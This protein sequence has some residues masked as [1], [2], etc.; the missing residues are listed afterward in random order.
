MRSTSVPDD[1]PARALQD[2]R[3]PAYRLYKVVREFGET[4]IARMLADAEALEDQ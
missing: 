1:K 3:R 4:S 2:G